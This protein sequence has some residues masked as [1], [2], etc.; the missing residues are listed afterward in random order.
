MIWI[1]PYVNKHEVKFEYGINLISY[2]KI[3]YNNYKII[4]HAVNHSKFKKINFIK[5]KKNGCLIYD[6]KS[7]LPKNS[8]NYK[9]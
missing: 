1:D 4:I 3:K 2:K 6:V 9:L 8:V 5:L 7:T